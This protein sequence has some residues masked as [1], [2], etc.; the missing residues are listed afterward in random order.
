MDFNH[1]LYIVEEEAELI[2]LYDVNDSVIE[3]TTSNISL[4]TIFKN[5]IQ[6]MHSPF[7]LNLN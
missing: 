7:F 1:A 4:W 5:L 3:L 6:E 2:S